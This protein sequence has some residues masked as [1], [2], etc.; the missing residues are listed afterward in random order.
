MANQRVSTKWQLVLFGWAIAGLLG[1]YTLGSLWEYADTLK[2]GNGWM[3]KVGFCADLLAIGVWIWFHVFRRWRVTRLWCLLAATIMGIFLV[4]HAAAVTKY[5]SAKK[6]AVA[7]VGN[8]ASGL[9]QITSAGTKGIVEGAGAVANGQRQSGAPN[10]AR[11][12]VATGV[13]SAG[14]ATVKNGQLLADATMRMEEQAQ[15]STFLSA[16]YMNGKMFAVIYV[17]LLVLSGV[18]FLVFELG[19]AEE[20][21]DD[22]GVPNYADANSSYYDATR[23][24]E[25]WGNR[26]QLAP[27][28]LNAPTTPPQSIPLG[29]PAAPVPSNVTISSVGAPPNHNF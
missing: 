19:K 2:A 6:E 28:K 1:F 17:V 5:L 8:L 24:E 29:F 14:D 9:A 3:L 4:V 12:T 26:G 11:A 27:H 18:T 23:A 20:D 16:D 22:D 21:D 10:T 15:G 7:N 25:W 13:K